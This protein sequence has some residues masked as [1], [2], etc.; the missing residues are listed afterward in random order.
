MC[1]IVILSLHM[2][3]ESRQLHRQELMAE[4]FAL[5]RVYTVGF[6]SEQ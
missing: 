4:L 1:L 6:P 3:I 2:A 5:F